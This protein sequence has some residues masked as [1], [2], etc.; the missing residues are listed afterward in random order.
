[1]SRSQSLAALFRPCV[2]PRSIPCRPH[3]CFSTTIRVF[4]E[5]SSQTTTPPP[6]PSLPPNA[7]AS[8]PPTPQAAQRAADLAAAE[9]RTEADSAQPPK[10]KPILPSKRPSTQ[11][12]PKKQSS[13]FPAPSTLPK[14]AF[15][16]AKFKKTP[17][18]AVTKPYQPPS[19]ASLPPPQYHVSRSANKNLPV[20]TDTKRGGNLHLTTV[21]KIT[22]DLAA[23]RDE[24]R[25]HLNKP[26]AEVTINSLTGHVVIKGHHL[27]KITEF[28]SERGM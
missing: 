16:L 13:P 7:S 20:Y 28:L 18:P 25:V 21:R 23:L 15:Q 27:R 14:S 19:P 4:A 5:Q 1:M 24:L 3:S 2:A 9:A 22:G 10:P 8:P 12:T 6:T 26:E 17:R 11:T